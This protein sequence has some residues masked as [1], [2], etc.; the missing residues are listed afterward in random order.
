VRAEQAV[1]IRK[2]GVDD[3]DLLVPLFDAYRQFYKQRADPLTARE[4]LAA[5]LERG[6]SVVF[7]ATRGGA[8]CGF[9]QL[10]PSFCSVAARPIWILYDL[11]VDRSVRREG[12][13]RRLMEAA[14]SLASATGAQR[15]VLSTANDNRGAQAL[16]ESLGY[17]RDNVFWH[18]ELN[19]EA[20]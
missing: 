5:R 3:L 8:G 2:A 12:V 1:E 6:E 10:Y 4:F 13:A 18:Y 17:R 19:L 16:Y 7:L 15:L 11:F 14:R 9:V 20:P